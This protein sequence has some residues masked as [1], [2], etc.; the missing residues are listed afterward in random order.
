MI[1]DLSSLKRIWFRLRGLD[2]AA[3]VVT[4]ATGSKEAAAAMRAEVRDLLPDHRHFD[5]DAAPGVPAWDLWRELRRRFLGLR[6]GMAAVLF[7]GSPEHSSLRLAAFLL[8]PLKVLAYNARGERHHLHPRA[9]IAS[10][11]FFRGVPLDRIWVRPWFF[12]FTRDRSR[13]TGEARVIEGRRLSATRAAAAV[14][15]PFF[16]Y[17]LSHG[18]AVRMYNLLREA[19]IEYD[20]TLFSF[21]EN[22]T[23]ADFEAMRGICARLVLVP[24]PRYR[25]PRWSTLRPPEVGEYRSRAMRRAIAGEKPR[26]LQVEYTQLAQYGGGILVEHDIT[27]DLYGQIYARNP[28]LA[29]WWD[30]WRWFVYEKLA[31]V[32]KNA[33][34]V[35]SEKDAAQVSHPRAAVI[36][37]GVNLERFRPSPER[38]G[39]RVL[40]IGSF[41]HFPNRVALRFLLDEV[42]ARIRAAFPDAELTVV[43]GPDPL[44][45][46]DGKA[47]PAAGGMRLE[48]FVADVRPLYEAANLVLVPTL[49][50]AGTNVKVLEAMAMERAVLSTTSGCGGLGLE[51]GRSVWIADGGEAFAAGAVRLLGDAELR[52]ELAGEARRLV[53]ARFS[54]RPLGIRQRD[55][56][57]EFAPAPLRIERWDG[58]DQEELQRI[59]QASPEAA[60]WRI[61][62]YSPYQ[63]WLAKLDG[64]VTGFAVTRRTGA[65]EAELL[66]LAVAPEWRGQGVGARLLEECLRRNPGEMFLEVR[67]SNQRA[68]TLYERYGFQRT[69]IRPAYYDNPVEAGIVM[70]L[71]TC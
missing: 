43:A 44:L 16:P 20:I 66:N 64:R 34:V 54:W 61:E 6:V 27:F 51:H 36:A 11:L 62:D 39:H 46:W 50:S 31:L 22:E 47:L 29:A 32:S 45:H 38:P 1:F 69:G 56:W 24:K 35:M 41:R 37:N 48:G 25:E 21:V 4:F 68:I 7:D 71:R 33:V 67:E 17:P 57:R 59:Q 42:W 3:V 58:R 53:V 18:G 14:L 10:W 23:E 49:V 65:D 19:S 28:T 63:A 8:S 52:R 26:L 13:E 60:Q 30:W 2:P 5:I 9:P 55:L 40:F 12:P 70:R 15:T